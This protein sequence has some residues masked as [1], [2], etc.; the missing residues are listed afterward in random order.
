ME[1]MKPETRDRL[2][3]A[4]PQAAPEDILE[5]ERLLAQRFTI[6]P[7]IL[8]APQEGPDAQALE[9]RLRTL[10]ARLFLD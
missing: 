4:R 1:P 10:Y 8:R 2:L 7:S 5:Y 9:A 6:N 3:N